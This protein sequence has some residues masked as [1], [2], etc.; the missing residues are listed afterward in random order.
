MQAVLAA[1]HYP[2]DVFSS[3]AKGLLALQTAHA[4]SDPYEVLIL[5]LHIPDLLGLEILR[6]IRDDGIRVKTIVLSGEHELENVAPILQLGAHDYIRKPFQAEHLLNSVRNALSAFELEDEVSRMHSRAEEDAALY[7]FLINASPD[8]VYLLDEEGRFRFANQQ[9]DNFFVLRPGEVRGQ[10]WHDVFENLDAHLLQQL[11]GHFNERRTGVRAT[12]A[13][14][15]EYASPF[16][17]R[18]EY[19]L[20][21][22]G[23]YEGRSDE[24]TGKYL[25]T[26]GVIRDVTDV[27]R[28]RKALQQ[29]QDKFYSL[30]MDSPEAVFIARLHDGLILEHNPAFAT[31]Y[32]EITGSGDMDLGMFP[33]GHDASETAQQTTDAQLWSAQHPRANFIDGLLNSPRSYEHT[34]TKLSQGTERHLELRARRLEVENTVCMLATLRDRTGERQA[35][36]DRLALQEQLQ[37]AGRMEA[38]GQVTGGI[39]HDFNNI[40]SSMIGFAEL[41]QN[42]RNRLDD[43]QID[44]F[45]QE[46]VTAGHRARDLISQMLTFTKAKRGDPVPLDVSQTISDVSRMLRAAIPSTIVIDNQF[47]SDLPAVMIDPVQV[48]QVIINLLIN[49]RD[50]IE[51]NGRIDLDVK[52][53]QKD[54]VCR[55]CGEAFKGE[56]VDIVVS[57]SGHGIPDE[58][59]DRVF[60]MYF[61][62]RPPDKG[63]GFGLWLVNSLVHEHHGHLAVTSAAGVGTQFCIS[64]PVAYGAKPVTQ[65]ST[66][67]TPVM[68]GRIVVVDDEAS[69]AN[70]VGELLRDSGYPTVVFTESPQALDYLRTHIDD[71]ALLLTDGAM[72]L[73]SGTQLIE[74]ARDLRPDLPVIFFT[75]YTQTM[76]KQALNA[77]GVNAVLSKPFGIEDMLDAVRGQLGEDTPSPDSSTSA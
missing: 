76:D 68:Q 33:G 9:L 52:R 15:F 42:S 48:Q 60:D 74:K 75:G 34:F 1:H 7:D 2:A 20:S 63:T 28:T 44:G 23:L 59:I 46:V 67:P 8:L 21:A 50:A 71:V 11:S 4:S 53:A 12:V 72:P 19:E 49:A 26:Y 38:I 66:I 24:D 31:L 35:E 73:I 69:V 55:T 43:S 5:D 29:S 64:L 54:A 58:I 77:L 47:E 10:V 65:T 22:I 14:E 56:Y 62:T 37:Q 3:G 70:F 18:H 41:V 57:D 30:F 32:G 13:E 17:N 51:G 6:A 27:K 39:A 25:G 36:A 61:T 16:G 45:L 40:L